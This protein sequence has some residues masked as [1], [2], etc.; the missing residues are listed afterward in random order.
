MYIHVYTCICMWIRQPAGFRLFALTTAAP[1]DREEER[2]VNDNT[3]YDNNN[4]NN[5]N[6]NIIM[7]NIIITTTMIPSEPVESKIGRQ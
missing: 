4:N 5:N 3:K 7:I 2:R 1:I 6:N